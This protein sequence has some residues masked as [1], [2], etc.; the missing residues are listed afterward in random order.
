MEKLNSDSS[1]QN[2][3]EYAV[4]LCNAANFNGQL[5]HRGLCYRLPM[6][7]VKLTLSNFK[8]KERVRACMRAMHE[9]Q[10]F[11]LNVSPVPQLQTI[12]LF[13]FMS[14]YEDS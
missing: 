8:K 2:I 13:T 10:H 4:D 7:Y 1:Q 9:I 5:L 12:K 3:Y 6:L 14:R 11:T